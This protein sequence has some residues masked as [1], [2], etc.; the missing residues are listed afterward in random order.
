M[1]ILAMT[2]PL[3][4]IR[5]QVWAD[6]EFSENILFSSIFLFF[7]IPSIPE[8]SYKFLIAEKWLFAQKKVQKEQKWAEQLDK[9]NFFVY[10]SKLTQLAN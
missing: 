8:G 7:W 2:L 4:F 9:I 5:G 10:Y 3:L 1:H 6:Q